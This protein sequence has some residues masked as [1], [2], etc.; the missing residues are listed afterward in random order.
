MKDAHCTYEYAEHF[1]NLP[2]IHEWNHNARRIKDGQRVAKGF[3]YVIDNNAEGMRGRASNL[4]RCQ[5][6]CGWEL[7]RHGSL[8]PPRHRASR[9]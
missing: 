6:E 4:D 2:A 5:L 7:L 8:W 3:S 9:H 1:K